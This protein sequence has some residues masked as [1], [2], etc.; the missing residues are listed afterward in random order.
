MT[1]L[2]LVGLCKYA[3]FMDIMANRLFKP[4]IKTCFVRSDHK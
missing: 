3:Q 1:D 2:L 4:G